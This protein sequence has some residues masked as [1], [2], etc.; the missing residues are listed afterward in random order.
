MIFPSLLWAGAEFSLYLPGYTP[1]RIVKG[2]I[3]NGSLD[4]LDITDFEITNRYFPEIAFDKTHGT[5]GWDSAD[6]LLKEDNRNPNTSFP[7][8]WRAKIWGDD[9][10]T[11]YID[12]YA[13]WYTSDPT[14]RISGE[15]FFGDQSIDISFN[16]LPISLPQFREYDVIVE[17][18]QIPEPSCIVIFSLGCLLASK[19]TKDRSA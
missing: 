5:D 19:R 17:I 13:S 16:T 11:F 4:G 7:K 12:I 6:V 9:L 10:E 2:G 15:V 1:N 3:F 8:I 14:L 18:S